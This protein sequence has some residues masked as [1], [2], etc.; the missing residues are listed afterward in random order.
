[1]ENEVASAQN[2][3]NSDSGVSSVLLERQVVEHP[4]VSRNP[5]E[6]NCFG[7]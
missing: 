6:D 1:M 2:T 4:E 7:K 3:A 5:S